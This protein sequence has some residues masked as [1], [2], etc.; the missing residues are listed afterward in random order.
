MSKVSIVI[1]TYNQAD[2][3]ESAI[4]SALDQTHEDIELLCVNDGSTDGTK[5]IL[6]RLE[7]RD[8]RLKV[9]HQENRGFSAA[10]NLATLKSRGEFLAHLDSDDLM[11]PDKIEKQLDYLKNHP[12]IDIVHSA[13]QVIDKNGKHLLVQRGT[14]E[15]PDVFFAKMLF[16][17]IMP[18]PTTM[19]GKAKKM[20]EVLYREHFKRSCDYDR[21]LRLAEKFRF[22]YLDLPLTL[23]RR[24]DR[25]LTN[26]LEK[27]KEEQTLSLRDF[28]FQVLVERIDK[29]SLSKDEK[30]LLKGQVAYNIEDFELAKDYFLRGDGG[31]FSFYLGNTLLRLGE[32]DAAL[33]AYEEGVDRDP[34]NAA[35]WNNLGVLKI[36]M[37]E[38]E[39]ADG[40]FRKALE[41]RPGYL[42]PEL[43]LKGGERVTDR[44]LRRDLIP[45]HL[46]P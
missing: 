15:A 19:L 44:E 30:L 10:A 38:R 28:P 4:Q 6:N 18:N 17:S 25:N 43:N 36:K 8:P 40:C 33:V 7:K 14:E 31:V 5:E 29:A 3:L 2:Y 23:W 13:I 34:K 1:P 42:D 39:K 21:V 11:V 46:S 20:K 32:L 26:E 35:L 27:Y 9:F 45:Y 41:L 22:G 16:R 24:H 12:D 37:G